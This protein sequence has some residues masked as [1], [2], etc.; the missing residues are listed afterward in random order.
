VVRWIT[1]ALAGALVALVAF[2]ALR[3]YAPGDGDQ[4]VARAAAQ[5]LGATLVGREGDGRWKVRLASR[6]FTVDTA[7]FGYDP[8]RGYRGVAATSCR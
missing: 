7:A 1:C 8:A 3:D 4:T 5:T 2:V 6:C